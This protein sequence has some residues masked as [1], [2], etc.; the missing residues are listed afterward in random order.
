MGV[1][2]L[3]PSREA[4]ETP[5][6]EQ[7]LDILRQAASDLGDLEAA[8]PSPLI[9]TLWADLLAVYE[10]ALVQWNGRAA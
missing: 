1:V 5:P 10:R 8:Q 3:F 6:D 9:R 4:G 7:A 2:P